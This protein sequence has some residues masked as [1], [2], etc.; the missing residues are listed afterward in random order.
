MT[1]QTQVAEM[2]IQLGKL[3]DITVPLLESSVTATKAQV[4]LATKLIGE[5]Q[6]SLIDD[7]HGDKPKFEGQPG[8]FFLWEL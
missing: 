8:K 1:A 5:K 3:K 4:D 6:V 7:K 2:A